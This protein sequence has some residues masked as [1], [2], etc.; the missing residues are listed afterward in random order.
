MA[1]KPRGCTS[2]PAP[3][4]GSGLV[5]GL[6]PLRAV[7]GELV[8]VGP[9]LRQH[10]LEQDRV[11]IAGVE[12]VEHAADEAVRAGV[13]QRRAAGAGLPPDARELVDLVA[14]LAAEQLR[15]LGL[16]LGYEVDAEQLGTARDP[17]GAVLVREADEEAR[18]VDARLGGEADQAARALALRAGGDDEHRVVEIADERVEGRVGHAFHARTTRRSRSQPSVET[19][20]VPSLSFPPPSGPS[21]IQR[22]AS[23]RRR[24]E[25]AKISVSPSAASARSITRSARAASCSSVSPPGQSSRHTSQPGRSTRISFVVRPSYTP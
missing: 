20:A 7:E 15:Q 2:D 1:R 8:G 17:V 9:A 23:S 14:G 18:R 25:W 19:V 4:G 11:V 22:P 16:L 12:P 21:P 10:R 5:P 6:D 13:E 3:A 24:C